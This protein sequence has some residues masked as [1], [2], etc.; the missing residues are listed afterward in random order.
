MIWFHDLIYSKLM[1]I[2]LLRNS[3]NVLIKKISGMLFI[4]LKL[5]Y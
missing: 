1:L 4:Q 5:N 2:N 3:K